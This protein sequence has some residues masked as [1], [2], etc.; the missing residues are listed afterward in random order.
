MKKRKEEEK[1]SERGGGEGGRERKGEVLSS[2][3][4]RGVPWHR[5]VALWLSPTPSDWT[6]RL[7]ST[8]LQ[9]ETREEREDG[10]Q[11]MGWE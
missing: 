2:V 9:R 10:N 5:C 4:Q 1:E 3:A 11:K 7:W 6:L 8:C